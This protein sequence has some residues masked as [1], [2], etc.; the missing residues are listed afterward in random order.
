MMADNTEERNVGSE[1]T[2]I[3]EELRKAIAIVKSE[4]EAGHERN[5]N[6]MNQE[7]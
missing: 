6:N 1:V 5:I 7:D 4:E 3:K 2:I